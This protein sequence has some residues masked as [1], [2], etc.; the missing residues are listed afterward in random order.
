MSNKPW[1]RGSLFC[2]G[3]RAP[4][5]RDRKARWRYLVHAHTRAGRI[6][7]KGQWVADVLLDHLS[8]AGRCDPSYARLAAASQAGETVVCETI[9]RL[10]SLGLLTWQRRIARIGGRTRQIS[11]AYVILVPS[12]DPAPRPKPLK[13][14]ESSSTPVSGVATGFVPLPM[15]VGGLSARFAAKLMEERIARRAKVT[16]FAMR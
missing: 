10:A 9:K 16:R 13:N 12:D 2:D 4:L 1:H 11:N 3:P 14:L 15:S 7:P 8:H 5:D 6:T